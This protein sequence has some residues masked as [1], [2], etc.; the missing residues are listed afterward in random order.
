MS[1]WE[2]DFSV[3]IGVL[4]VSLLSILLLE[5]GES[6]FEVVTVRLSG[7]PVVRLFTSVLKFFR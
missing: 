5:D 7:C 1:R 4:F 2:R 6:R 3:T